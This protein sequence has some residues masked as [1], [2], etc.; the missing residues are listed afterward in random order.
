M[1][2]FASISIILVLLLSFQIKAQ[3]PHPNA[4]NVPSDLISKFKSNPELHLND[5][6]NTLLKGISSDEEKVKILHDWTTLNIQYDV[7]GY[8]GNGKIVYNT[9]DVIKTGKSVCEGYC[10]V[11]EVLLTTAKIEN[12]KVAGYARGYGFDIFAT[13]EKFES[14]H[15]WTAVKLN[16]K[17]QLIDVTWNSGFIDGIRFVP[18]YSL[19]YFLI[20]P[21]KFVYTHFPE[22]PEWQLLSTPLS[23]AQFTNM[24]YLTDRFFA[25]GLDLQTKST[26]ILD[27]GA[28]FTLEIKVPGDVHFMARLEDSDKNRYDKATLTQRTGENGKVYVVFP[29][30][31]NYTLTLFAKHI[32]EQGSYSGVADFGLR[33]SAGSDAKF[34]LLFKKFVEFGCRLINPVTKPFK[35]GANQMVDFEFYAPVDEVGVE[36]N[37]E[38]TMLTKNSAGNFTGKV[39][40]TGYPV[41]VFMKTGDRLQFLCSWE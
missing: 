13:N 22:E 14:N 3:T 40:I 1:L 37:E 7:E 18:N 27:T 39:K 8:F 33:A 19:G 29:K 24:P 26:R 4:M 32:D 16:G 36:C 31:G 41:K 25:L 35:I 30:K 9:F 17:W 10:N 34:P 15:T 23:F 2:R 28:E 11:F 21:E 38:L 6:V 20:S 5:F 12:K